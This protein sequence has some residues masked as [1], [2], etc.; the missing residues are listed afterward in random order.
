MGY[1]DLS[2]LGITFRSSPVEGEQVRVHEITGREQLGQLFEFHVR[3]SVGTDSLPD[4]TLEQLLESPCTFTLGSG[5]YD[6]IH[7]IVRDVELVDA[8]EG[9]R[10]VYVATV[11]PSFWLLTLSRVSRVFQNMTVAEM[12]RDVLMR[13]G[14]GEEDYALHLQSKGDKREF[15]VQYEES[16]WD[17]LMR[18]FEHEGYYYWFEHTAHGTRLVVADVNHASP[19][20]PGGAELAYRELAGTGR[21]T[22]SVFAWTHSRR[23]TPRRVVLKDYNEQNPALP[24]VGKADVGVAGGFGVLFAYGEH[25]ESGDAG[26]RLATKRAERCRVEH[27]S[28]RGQTDSTR[29]RVGYAFTL[30]EHFRAEN[31]RK[32]LLTAIQHHAGLVSAPGEPDFY[33]YRAT[34]QVLPTD[35]QFRPACITPW[36]RIDGVMHAHVDSDSSGTFSTINAQGRYRVRLPFDSTGNAGDGASCWVRMC[37]SYAGSGYGSHFPLH[38]G[39]E[40]L[41]AFVDGDPDRPIIVGAVPNAH[42]PSPT[43]S[44]NATQS[45]IRSASGIQ[46]SMDDFHAPPPSSR[47][48]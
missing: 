38:K 5:A 34:I 28:V 23:R 48:A 33:G 25:F 32:Y 17:F 12:A 29:M 6:A 2:R 11:V 24:M 44:K 31:N 42:T 21:A 40:V 7:G 13:A 35:V 27:M 14:F 47:A 4:A 41:V 1:D 16:D 43:A 18:W 19:A 26:K 15:C 45:V 36:P 3:F 37:Q 39:A 30:T 20:L 46:F 9:L 8:R 22:E 10:E